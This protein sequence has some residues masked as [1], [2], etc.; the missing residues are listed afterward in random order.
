MNPNN[1]KGELLNLRYQPKRNIDSTTEANETENFSE[2]FSSWLTTIALAELAFLLAQFMQ[3]KIRGIVIEARYEAIVA[4]VGLTAAAGTGLLFKLFLL[5]EKFVVASEERENPKGIIFTSLHSRSETRVDFDQMFTGLL[6][7][8]RLKVFRLF[9]LPVAQGCFLYAGIVYAASFMLIFLFDFEPSAIAWA[10]DC[11]F[12]V[13][14]PAFYLLLYE[15]N[16]FARA[17][18]NIKIMRLLIDRQIKKN[19][20]SSR[21]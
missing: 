20:S 18:E 6:S 5:T 21:D 4:L 14:V 8:K 11:F 19:I 15:R 1:Q 10:R 16:P 17:F 3:I 9:L 2:K 12:M 13:I 7:G